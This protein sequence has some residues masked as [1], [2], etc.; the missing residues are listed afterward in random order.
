MNIKKD[1]LQHI[2]NEVQVEEQQSKEVLTKLEELIQQKKLEQQQNAT[3]TETRFVGLDNYKSL[4]FSKVTMGS[5]VSLLKNNFILLLAIPFTSINVVKNEK[6][7]RII[8]L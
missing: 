2:L 5:L 3:K 8:T 4:I 6:W 7:N 1:E